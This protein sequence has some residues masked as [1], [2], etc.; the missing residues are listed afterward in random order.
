ME[1][2]IVTEYGKTI[3]LSDI[4]HSFM[5]LCVF[6]KKDPPYLIGAVL[7][8]NEVVCFARIPDK[9]MAALVYNQI[10][11][12]IHHPE[13]CKDVH[14]INVEMEALKTITAVLDSVGEP[15]D[16]VRELLLMGALQQLVDGIAPPDSKLKE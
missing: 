11:G 3:K 9:D 12:I 14:D 10:R 4:K 1:K 5:E 16:P 6:D 15:G 13:V 8:N 2:I 7:K